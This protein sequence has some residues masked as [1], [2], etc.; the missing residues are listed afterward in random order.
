MNELL[1]ERAKGHAY[2]FSILLA[3]LTMRVLVG[4]ALPVMS[5]EQTL[6]VGLT[7][8]VFLA[9]VLY[10]TFFG[11]ELLDNTRKKVSHGLSMVLAAGLFIHAI[12]LAG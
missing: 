10:R 4:L 2:M 9:P 1:S 8:V 3:A 11:E 6:V 7:T 12:A 5:W